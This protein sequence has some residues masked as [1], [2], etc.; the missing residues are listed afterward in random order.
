MKGERG[1]KEDGAR[2][3]EKDRTEGKKHYSSYRLE[4]PVQ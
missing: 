3:K 2:T 4:W 1:A